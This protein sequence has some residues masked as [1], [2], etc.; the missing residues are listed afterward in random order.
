M[1]IMRFQFVM[2]SGMGPGA[3]AEV[4]ATGMKA[5]R[6]STSDATAKA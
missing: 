1:N 6:R 2:F 3:E 5:Q 4:L